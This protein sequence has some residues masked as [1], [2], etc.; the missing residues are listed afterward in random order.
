[1][2]R[3]QLTEREQESN[4]DNDAE[5]QQQQE[6]IK[7]KGLASSYGAINSFANGVDGDVDD[8]DNDDDLSESD[9]EED[10]SFYDEDEDEE[11]EED[12][13]YEYEYDDSDDEEGRRHEKKS[14]CF[15]NCLGIANGKKKKK[16]RRRLQN[17]R[18]HDRFRWKV[19]KPILSP[20][21][22]VYAVAKGA[23]ILIT[24][25]DDV[26]DSPAIDSQYRNR[27]GSLESRSSATT[28]LIGGVRTS[29]QINAIGNHSD[30]NGIDY[31]N[32]TDMNIGQYVSFRH[33]LGALFWFLVLATAYGVERG[34]FKIMIDRMGPFR[35]VVATEFVMAVH[36][37][38]L[39]V[40]L[41]IRSL[42][43]GRQ[44]MKGTVMLPLAD[45]GLM[46]IFD[47]IQLLL[48]V[49]SGSHV[50][51][52]LTAV[53]VHFT[54]PASTFMNQCLF[55][56]HEDET[57]T[58]TSQH[59]FGSTL[60]FISSILALSPAILT[61]TYPALFS[62]ENVMA[63]RSAWNTILFAT[64]CIP[65][66]ISQIYKE[67]TLA[68]F[69]QP[70]D[71]TLLNMLLSLFSFAFAFIISPILYALQGLA[72]TPSTPTD[73]SDLKVQSWIHQYPSQQISKNFADSLQCFTGR[74][75]NEIQIRG[76]PEQAYCDFA[77][78]FVFVY[79]FSIITVNHAV[80]K[81][82]NAG[83]IKIMHRGIS[84]GIILSVVLMM[85]YQ[86]FVDDQEYGFFPNVY[87]ITCAF[88]LVIG[89]EVYHKVNLEK[90]SFETDYP[91]VGDLYDE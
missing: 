34:V 19:F 49:I 12:D 67:R 32:D 83:A 81:I 70:V 90:P 8:G 29:G 6:H 17:N 76:Y 66:A 3:Q 24:N 54:I 57:G 20:I 10:S 84:A 33:K 37:L 65:A 36:A 55:P 4:R 91:Q 87:H 7:T 62:S 48:A 82:C 80:D 50:A 64:S 61:L 1:M 72:D 41:L 46:A 44:A 73:G 23:I 63:N 47:T 35:M 28:S 69:A 11:E 51:P 14:L 79:V 75:S 39:G 71:S 68:A 78:G 56:K 13:E 22:K 89:S 15:S 85:Y 59:L 38:V 18:N 5:Q 58:R 27:S 53:L 16:H 2:L 45:I 43:C 40:S 88:V 52:M 77:W 25:V 60:I 86:I 26:W 30:H 31:G 21:I 9:E 74:L 42:T